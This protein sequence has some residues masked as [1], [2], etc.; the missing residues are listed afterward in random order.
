MKRALRFSLRAFL[1]AI[2]LCAIWMA[3]QTNKARNQRIAVEV[4]HE[5]GGAVYYDWMLKPIY[6]AEGNVPFLK[7]IKNPE[8][9][10]APSWLRHVLGDDYFQHVVKIGNVQPHQISVDVISAIK[11]LPGLEEINLQSDASTA[12][13]LTDAEI[14][15]LK[16]RIEQE[17]DIKVFGPFKSLTL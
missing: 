14:V 16:A 11:N 13:N 8:T 3:Y 12:P 4:I 17:C 15:E 10:N 2:T 9:I 5:A 1:L 6:D 7:V